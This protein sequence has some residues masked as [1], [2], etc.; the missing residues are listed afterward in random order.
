MIRHIPHA[1]YWTARPNW[2]DMLSPILLAHFA[3]TEVLWS[4]A[5]DADII[6]VGSIL[7]ALPPAWSGIVVGS[8]KLKEA[9]DID[10][11]QAKVLALR[12]P[13]SAKGFKGDYVLGDPGLL[14]ADLVRVDKTYELGIIPHWSDTAL[15]D[16]YEFKGFNPRIIRASG[17]PIEVVKEIGRCKRVVSSSLH[18]VIVA[19]AFGIP[20]RI[21]MA[22]IFARE[23]GDF[24]FRD[25]N[26]AVGVKHEIGLMQEAPRY[27]VQE[28]Q[29]E[30]YDALGSAGRI[31]MGAER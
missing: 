21:E 1:F 24:K 16:R 8:G 10:L 11:S 29:H 6:C 2:G 31:M 27:R 4:P 5:K 20:R 23:G 9:S 19:D 25:H 18:G 3:R 13:L 30:L 22:K 7:E 14:A 15:E 17:D 26:G 12:G 28:R